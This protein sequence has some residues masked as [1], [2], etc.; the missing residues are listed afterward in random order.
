MMYGDAV[1]CGSYAKLLSSVRCEVQIHVHGVSARYISD[2]G[3]PH[4]GNVALQARSAVH[5]ILVSGRMK[6]LNTML[7]SLLLHPYLTFLLLSLIE[8]SM[9]LIFDLSFGRRQPITARKGSFD[10]GSLL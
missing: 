4:C 1:I 6:N 9:S 3:C 2:V 7:M 8:R 10:F 5:L